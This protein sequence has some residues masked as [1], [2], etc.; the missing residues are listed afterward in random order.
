VSQGYELESE[1]LEKIKMIRPYTMLTLPRLITLYQQA[2]FCERFGLRGSFVECGTWKGGAVGLMALANLKYASKPRHLHLFDSFEGVPEPD[3]SVDGE[4][5]VEQVLAV[6]GE[7]KGRLQPVKGFYETYANGTGTIGINQR[8]LEEL[9][10]Y[11]HDYVHYHK[12]WFQNTLPCDVSR[13]DEIAILRID[14]DWYASTKIC[15]DYLYDKVV[16]GGF[17]VIDDYGFYEGCRRAV[18]E[19]VEERN[20]QV[21]INYIDSSGRYWIKP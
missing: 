15:L 6:G 16:K 1:A 19:F 2:V 18:D 5:A 10:G 14:G 11:A 9:I 8:L 17:V 3:Q 20:I 21:F 7:A 13:M 12:G 4:R